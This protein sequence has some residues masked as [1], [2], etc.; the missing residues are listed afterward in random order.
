[1][2]DSLGFT[3]DGKSLGTSE[4]G[5]VPNLILVSGVNSFLGL[6]SNCLRLESKS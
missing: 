6:F 5:F 3:R 2:E 4:S 1:M